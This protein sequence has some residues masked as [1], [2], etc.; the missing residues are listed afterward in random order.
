MTDYYV[1]NLHLKAKC[2]L[3]LKDMLETN[4]VYLVKRQ[5]SQPASAHHSSRMDSW[6]SESLLDLEH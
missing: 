5:H 2:G 4:G 3:F 6:S 1:D